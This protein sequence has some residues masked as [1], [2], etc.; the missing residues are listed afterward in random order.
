MK[1]PDKINLKKFSKYS[2]TSKGQVTS[3]KTGDYVK[4]KVG[5]AGTFFMLYND[6]GD[7]IKVL[8]SDIVEGMKEGSALLKKGKLTGEQVKEIR[9]LANGGTSQKVIAEKYGIHQ[10]TVSEIKS[11]KLFANL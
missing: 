6:S 9:S 10:S 7:R 3:N 2:F 4:G 5:S 8:Q 11:K 1:K